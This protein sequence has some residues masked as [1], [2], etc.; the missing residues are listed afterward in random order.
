M[1]CTKCNH[2]NDADAQF[3]THCGARL[4]QLPHTPKPAVRK[5]SPVVLVVLAVAVLVTLGILGISRFQTDRVIAF[6]GEYPPVKPIS[7]VDGGKTYTIDA[8][9]GQVALFFKEN[10]SVQEAKTSIEMA[11]GTILAQVPIM[12]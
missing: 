12:H 4:P 7:I 2:T 11:G 5:K 1:Y 10:I 6:Q 9:A 3:C 8:F